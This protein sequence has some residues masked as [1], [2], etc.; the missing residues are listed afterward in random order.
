MRKPRFCY[1]P[2]VFSLV[3]FGTEVRSGEKITVAVLD[4]EAKNLSQESAD[5]VTDLLRTELFKTGRFRV[6]ER[7]DIRKIIEEQRL[8]MSGL[9]DPEQAAE[10]GRL[11][12]VQKMMMGTVSKLDGTYFLNTRLVDVQSGLIHLAESVKCRG[13]EDVLSGA[14][15]D[16][17]LKIARDVGLE[18]TIVRMD[19]KTVSIDLGK[20]D[21]V[22]SGQTFEVLR[23]REETTGSED[24]G[25][26]IRAVVIGTVRITRVEDGFSEARIV[27]KTDGFREGDRVRL[28]ESET[29][30]DEEQLDVPPVF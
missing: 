28:K 15:A 13:G 2:L 8:Q 10:I 21:G 11:L 30:L 17:A 4:F 5:A 12:N 7:E 29:M 9:I 26:G 1:L 3:F 23:F 20:R 16:L 27:E 14:T 22:E 25:V 24:G 19:E 6:V 18:G